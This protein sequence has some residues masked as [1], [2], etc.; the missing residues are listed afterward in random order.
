MSGLF[1]HSDKISSH[2]PR[3][4]APLLTNTAQLS[5][6]IV[7]LARKVTPFHTAQAAQAAQTFKI[8]V[9]FFLSFLK[10][11]AQYMR[12]R[13]YDPSGAKTH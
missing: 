2:I 8:H 13:P 7:C 3:S 5:V 11:S 4:L 12:G 1:S 10:A 6:V 9:P